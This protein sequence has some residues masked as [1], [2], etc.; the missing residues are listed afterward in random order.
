MGESV[1]MV[2]KIPRC[3]AHP[4]MHFVLDNARDDLLWDG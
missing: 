4:R 3:D 2:G 1:V